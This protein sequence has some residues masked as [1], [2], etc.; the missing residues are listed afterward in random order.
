[1]APVETSSRVERS[2]ATRR[3]VSTK[4][5]LAL[6]GAIDLT[7]DAVKVANLVRVEID[8]NGNPLRAAAEDRIDEAIRFEGTFVQRVEL[9]GGHVKWW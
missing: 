5:S 7:I 2:S 1:M 4:L 6:R 8:A 9:V 3:S